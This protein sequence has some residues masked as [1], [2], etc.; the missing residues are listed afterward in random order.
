ME[1]IFA[2][3]RFEAQV[4]LVIA[5]SLL[6][7]NHNVSSEEMQKIKDFFALRQKFA[8]VFD[9]AEEQQEVER[10]HKAEQLRLEKERQARE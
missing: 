1:A 4:K 2:K 8:A 6:K 5:L 3:L 9:Q 7:G 10:R